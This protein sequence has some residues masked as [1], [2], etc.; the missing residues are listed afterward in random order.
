ME[1]EQTEPCIVEPWWSSKETLENPLLSEDCWFWAEATYNL[2]AWGKKLVVRL[3]RLCTVHNAVLMSLEWVVVDHMKA[4]RNSRFI[5]GQK[6]DY[7]LLAK[8]SSL[9]SAY[10]V[11]NMYKV[12]LYS[13]YVTCF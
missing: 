13:I 3:A 1:Y 8:G 6:N 10:T 9:Y 7:S 12:F 5:L 11:Q 4:G 2:E